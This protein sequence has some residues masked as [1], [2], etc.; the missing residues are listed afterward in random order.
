MKPSLSIIIPALNEEGNIRDCVGEVLAAVDGRFSDYE[1]LIFNDGSSDGTGGIADD[2][3]ARDEHIRV[4]HN[5]RNMGFGYNYRT[6][7][8]QAK[9]DYVVM[10]PGDNEIPSSSMISVLNVTG[11]ADIVIP[12]T[13]NIRARPPARRLISSLFTTMVNLLFG[14]RVRYYNGTVIHRTEILKSVSMTTDSFAYQAE[15]LVQLI[16]AGRGYVQ[17][18]MYLRDREHGSSKAFR[19]KNIIDVFRTLARLFVKVRLT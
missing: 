15:I 3:A 4:I 18:G 17:V 2:M 6:G 12:Y 10:F 7:V 11:T 14:L 8:E 19:I 9:K 1:I 16:K 5:G 13:V